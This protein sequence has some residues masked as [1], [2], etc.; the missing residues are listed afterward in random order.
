MRPGMIVENTIQTNRTLLNDAWCEFF[1]STTISWASASAAHGRC[2]T[3][4]GSTGDRRGKDRA[5]RPLPLRE[6]AEVQA[7]LREAVKRG[8]WDHGVFIPPAPFGISVRGSPG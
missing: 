4:I 2:T 3:P 7:V 8:G 6:R 5:E 1:G